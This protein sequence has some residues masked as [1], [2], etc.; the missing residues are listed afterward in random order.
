MNTR[1]NS[2]WHGTLVA[3][4]IA[5]NTNNDAGIAG[6]DW[7]A[8]ILPVRVLGRCG[9]DFSDILNGMH[10]PLYSAGRYGFTSI[11]RRRE[12]EPIFIRNR[13][14]V[15]F[16]G[17]EHL[18][19]RLTPQGGVVHFIS[20]AAGSV[21][22]GDLKPSPILAKGYDKDLSFMR[23]RIFSLV[24]TSLRPTKFAVRKPRRVKAVRAR[25]KP[26]PGTFT[27]R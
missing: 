11:V 9:G 19:E 15:V 12:L 18:Y 1:M 26:R 2:E 25:I 6:I 5:A 20:G 3:G 14:D 22:T 8:R 17:H 27:G 10:H 7:N 4:V 21:R 13:V 24:S 16:A 23:P